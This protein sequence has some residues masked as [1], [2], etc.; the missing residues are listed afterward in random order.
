MRQGFSGARGLIL[1]ASLLSPSF[2]FSI[3]RGRAQPSIPRHRIHVRTTCFVCVLTM[4]QPRRRRVARLLAIPSL[5]MASVPRLASAAVLS[6]R[7]RP[8][9]L[10]LSLAL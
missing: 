8:L 3:R 9:L 4:G 6:V 10:G 1:I 5:L 7:R 2:P